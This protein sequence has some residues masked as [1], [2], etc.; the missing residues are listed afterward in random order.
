MYLFYPRSHFLKSSVGR[1][2]FMKKSRLEL[3]TYKWKTFVVVTVVTAFNIPVVSR[4]EEGPFLPF[5]PSL[6]LP[7]IIE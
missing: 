2:K 6:F 5:L 1:A 7:P 4:L 3:R